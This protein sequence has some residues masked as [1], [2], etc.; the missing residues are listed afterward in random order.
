MKRAIS[1]AAITLTLSLSGCADMQKQASAYMPGATSQP[2][3]STV[4]MEGGQK[5]QYIPGTGQNSVATNSGT[6]QNEEESSFLG[7]M[8]K[9][10]TD[11]VKSE[12]TSGVRSA[13]RG[14][15]SR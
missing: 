11:S 12:A 4:A 10:A 8:V 5:V 9:S 13:V 15:F 6:N 7:D 14:M 3:A 2:A 1:F